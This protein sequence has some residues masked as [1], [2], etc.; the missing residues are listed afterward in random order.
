MKIIQRANCDCIERINKRTW[1][2]GKY[3]LATTITQP[4]PSDAPQECLTVFA[5]PTKGMHPKAAPL[6]FQFCPFCSTKYKTNAEIA[7]LRAQCES[8]ARDT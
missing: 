7:A 6:T 1:P 2:D 3:Q 4:L 8:D 5:R